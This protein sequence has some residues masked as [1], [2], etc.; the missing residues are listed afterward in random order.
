MILLDGDAHMRQRKLL[1]PAFHGEKMTALTGLMT[2]I[3]VEEIDGW[4]RETATQLHPGSSGSRSRSSCARSSGST[5]ASGSTCSASASPDA[6][7]R[8]Q[9]HQPDPAGAR[10]QLRPILERYGP[11]APFA[12]AQQEADELI[13]ALIRERRADPGDRGDILA[14]LIEARDEDDSPMSEEEIRDEL[15]TMLV[16]GHETTASTLAWAFERLQ[17]HPHAL[18]RLRDEVDSG[19]DDAYLTAT[20]QETL[21]RRPVLP[22]AAPRLVKKEIEIGDWT[23]PPD[24]ALIP[25][26]YLIHH[27]PEIYDDPYAFRPERFLD[28]SPGTYTWI[29]FGGGRR[30]CIGASFAMVEMKIVMSAVLERC[31]LVATGDGPEVAKRRN[32]TVRPAGGTSTVLVDRVPAREPEPVPA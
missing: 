9:V 3:A 13:Y 7:V 6:R 25:N 8:R 16:A 10:Q 21:R 32:I 28:E 31:E 26:G 20:I 5:W 1:L 30:R 14:M 24:V 19:D 23:Y 27:D 15:L 2:E 18:G 11:F 29:P 17:R 22:N 12:R 4:P